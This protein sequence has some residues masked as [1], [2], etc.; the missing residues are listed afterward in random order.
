M[1]I[2]PNVHQVDGIPPISNA[3]LITGAGG[4]VLIDAGVAWAA[5]G[6]LRYIRRLGFA[7]SDVKAIFIT[8]GDADHVGGL[9]ALVRETGA[10][11]V[12]HHAEVG[13]V[14]GTQK[15]RPTSARLLDYLMAPI[16]RLVMPSKPVAVSRPV[17]DGETLLG[18][19]VIHTPGHSPGSACYLFREQGVLFAGDALTHWGGRLAL[20]MAAYTTDMAQAIESIK[21]IAQQE[22][23]VCAFGHGPAIVR[24]A[25]SAIAAFADRLT[26]PEH[27]ATPQV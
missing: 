8:H 27:P 12:C 17:A 13:L 24:D 21:R 2:A 22:F 26:V 14:D 4:L 5:G 15:R 1:E 18:L 25:R 6:I 23:D 11:V 19:E 3:Y 9:H 20:P 7:L 10:A 16:V